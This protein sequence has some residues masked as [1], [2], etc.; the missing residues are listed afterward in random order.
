MIMLAD[1]I[2]KTR[3]VNAPTAFKE[4]SVTL[5][6]VLIA[7]F[8]MLHVANNI[9]NKPVLAVALLIYLPFLMLDFFA[10]IRQSVFLLIRPFSFFVLWILFVS[11][12]FW[13]VVPKVSLELIVTLSAFMVLAI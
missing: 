4:Q 11:S 5:Q 1:G 6:W 9:F 13:S 3:A 10:N 12:Y 2:I 8:L 7:I